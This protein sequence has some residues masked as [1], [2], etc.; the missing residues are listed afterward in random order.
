MSKKSVKKKTEEREIIYEKPTSKLY[1]KLH[2]KQAKELLG[3]QEEDTEKF[4]TNFLFKDSLGRKIRCHN[5]VTNRPLYLSILGALTQE[6]LRRRWKLNGENRI[7]GET[8]LV[9]NGQHTFISL[10][11]AVQKWKEDPSKYP[12]WETE[13]YIA[14]SIM[15]GISEDDEVVNTMDTCKPRSLADVLYRSP[16]FSDL[17]NK[18]RKKASRVLDYAVKLVWDRTGV[19]NAFQIRRTHAE[20]LDFI[21]RHPKIVE[22][23][24]HIFTEN[25]DCNQI[26]WYISP[27]S[28][29][30]LL[31]LMSCSL[32]ESRD[33]HSDENPRE[34]LLSWDHWDKACDFWVLLAGKSP[35]IE[36]VR[37]ALIKLANDDSKNYASQC[38]IVIKAWNLYLGDQDITAKSLRLHY[39]PDNDGIKRLAECPT[40]DGI[41]VGDGED[42]ESPTK[43]DP[44]PKEIEKQTEEIRSGSPS[45]EK[46]LKKKAKKSGLVGK[47]RWVND[48]IEHWRGR[49]V[50]I[51]TKKKTA[52]LKCLDGF[53]GAGN[54]RD[55]RLINLQETQPR[56]S[57]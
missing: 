24:N 25:G 29:A 26:G 57:Q 40:V 20:A 48:A 18:D 56:D 45:P 44:S 34:E 23:A 33:Y 10:V 2:S 6:I 41:D 13:P 30:G 11:L 8:G 46:P 9:L 42:I 7:I 50:E 36:A 32:T 5:N 39:A 14:V 22:C 19:K 4:G 51:D 49:V 16:F 21:A 37:T 17:E 47:I 3:W 15:F 43:G 38:A 35:E 31:Y 53:K 54:I 1:E 55:T 52:K 28:A 27:G 12:E